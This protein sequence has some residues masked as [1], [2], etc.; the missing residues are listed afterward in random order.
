MAEVLKSILRTPEPPGGVAVRGKGQKYSLDLALSTLAGSPIENGPCVSCCPGRPLSACLACL[1]PLI[2]AW[3]TMLP[4][5]GTEDSLSNRSIP[6]Q[7]PFYA[8]MLDFFVCYIYTYVLKTLIIPTPF[9]SL[10]PSLAPFPKYCLD[11]HILVFIF[12]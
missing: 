7:A 8:H 12:I 6:S 2:P 10:A 3:L 4:Q 5:Q 11:V 9:P 1:Q